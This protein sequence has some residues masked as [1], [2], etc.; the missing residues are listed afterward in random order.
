MEKRLT[1]RLGDARSAIPL[2]YK[3]ASHNSKFILVKMVANKDRL[4]IMLYA[5][6]GLLHVHQSASIQNLKMSRHGTTYV[7]SRSLVVAKFGNTNACACVLAARIKP[8][9]ESSS[10]R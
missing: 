6:S 8:W 9:S 10:A 1:V 2:C 4:Y 7:I 3:T 5:R